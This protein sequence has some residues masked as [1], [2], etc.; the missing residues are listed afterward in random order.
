MS[1]GNFLKSKNKELQD[2]I[3]YL[4]QENK[5]LHSLLEEKEYETEQIRQKLNLIRSDQERLGDDIRI[6]IQSQMRIESVK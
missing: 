6:N 2:S 3:T 5:K 1:E 4:T